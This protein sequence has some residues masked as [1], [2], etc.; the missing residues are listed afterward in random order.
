MSQ[1]VSIRLDEDVLL[2]LDRLSKITDRSRAWL[3]GHAVEQYVQHE[4]WQ[5]EAIKK[6]LSKVQDGSAKFTGHNSIEEWLHDWGTS[7]EGKAPIC[8]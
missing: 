2:N 6:T 3:M 7:K 4:A 8:K 1:S 5:A